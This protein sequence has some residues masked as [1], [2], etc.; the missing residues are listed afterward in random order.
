MW[1][2]SFFVKQTTGIDEDEIRKLSQDINTMMKAEAEAV[3]AYIQERI[4]ALLKGFEGR[5]AN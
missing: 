2:E 1:V 3:V 5:S 4:D